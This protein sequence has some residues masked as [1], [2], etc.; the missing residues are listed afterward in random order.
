MAVPV[1]PGAPPGAAHPDRAHPRQAFVDGRCVGAIVCK[2]DKHGESFRGYI[3]ML[4]VDKT[5]RKLNIGT[6]LVKRAVCAVAAQGA[7]EVVLEAE[8]TNAGALRLYQRLGF[9][10]D[11]RLARYYLSGADAY[12]LRMLLPPPGDEAAEKLLAVAASLTL[13]AA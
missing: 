9:V 10:R 4:V 7:D 5:V 6:E 8:A 13:G 12:R 3:A 2:L 11:K 1:L